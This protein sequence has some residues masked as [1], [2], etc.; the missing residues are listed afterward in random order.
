MKQ[1]RSTVAASLLFSSEQS[2]WFNITSRAKRWAAY[3]S[4]WAGQSASPCE[5]T[6]VLL[7]DGRTPASLGG[8]LLNQTTAG[9]TKVILTS[10]PINYS[11]ICA[12]SRKAAWLHF[13]NARPTCILQEGNGKEPGYY[14][15][16]DPTVVVGLTCASVTAWH[17]TT[18]KWVSGI[19]SITAISFHGRMHCVRR[20]YIR[21]N[22]QRGL[23][24]SSANFF[25]TQIRG[26]ALNFSAY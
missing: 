23:F 10:I 12:G 21:S 1:T 5:T 6:D 20:F 18:I 8:R 17:R 3:R 9:Y 26:Q 22:M 16:F 2:S 19:V 11:R 25:S 4:V 13:T 24:Y 15:A 14:P 7:T